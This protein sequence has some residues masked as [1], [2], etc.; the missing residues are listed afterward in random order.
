MSR[1]TGTVKW[2]NTEAVLNAAY[3]DAKAEL[4]A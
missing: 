4:A 1:K 3:A 2:F